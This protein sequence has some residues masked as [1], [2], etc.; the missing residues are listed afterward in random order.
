[1]WPGFLAAQI[2]REYSLLLIFLCKIFPEKLDKARGGRRGIFDSPF[3]S[4]PPAR[5]ATALLPRRAGMDVISIHAPREGG[6]CSRKIQKPR[7]LHFNP[8]PPR[9]GRRNRHGK[10]VHPHRH[11]NPRPPRGGR[12][13]GNQAIMSNMLAFQSTPPA[14]GATGWMCQFVRSAA[15]SI[16]APREGGDRTVCVLPVLASVFQSTPPARGAT[17]ALGDRAGR[18]A[19]FNPRPPRGGRL[20]GIRLTHAVRPISIHAPREGG[21]RRSPAS[22]RAVGHFNPRPPRG[23]RLKRRGPPS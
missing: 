18:P 21:D 14:R 17:A 23:G 15:I 9:G 20:H 19:D 10:P 12:H 16:H 6:D 2:V 22:L 5:G 8:R 1:M 13:R 3:Q 11:F 7:L 4:T